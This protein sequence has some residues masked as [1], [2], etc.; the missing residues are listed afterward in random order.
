MDKLQTIKVFIEVAKHQS[1]S[2]AAENLGMSAPAASRAIAELEGR[3][4]TKL[5]NRT[6]RLVRLTETGA[7]FFKDTQRILEDLDDAE[8]I[9]KGVY[10]TPSGILTITAPV[11]FGQQ[12]VMPVVNEYLSLHSEVSVKAMFYDRVTSL[13]E[14]ELDIAIRIGHLKD[15]SLYAKKVGTVR[16]IICGSPSYFK[17]SDLPKKPTDLLDHNLIFPTTFENT[18]TW[19]FQNGDKKELIKLNPRLMCNQNAA[20]L[21]AAIEG[22]GIT[23]LMSYQVG[24]ELEK[25]TLI[26]VLTGYEEEPLPV[27][28]V[29]VEGRRANA[30]V[31]SFIDLA[32]ERFRTNPFINTEVK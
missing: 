9:A 1:F 5:F 30:K 29:H 13:L 22:R 32:V 19:Q 26:A 12:H 27:H 10:S 18:L 14:E 16:R 20:A 8:S 17:K 28:V 3:L 2:I 4:R 15:S 31:R 23:R 11:L 7:R 24:E 25:G 21:K 6:T